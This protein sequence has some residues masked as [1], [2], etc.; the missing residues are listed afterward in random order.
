LPGEGTRA[1]G[2]GGIAQLRYD[3]RPGAFLET[4]YEGISDTRG[5]FVRQTV[6][7]GGV[8]LGSSFRLTIEDA[9][10]AN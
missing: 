10:A 7:G 9:L 4:R 5:S 2:S 1:T 8:R 3:L 6:L